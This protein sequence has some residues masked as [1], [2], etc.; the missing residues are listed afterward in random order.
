ML[1]LLDGSINESGA[2]RIAGN[3]V[4][5]A[6]ATSFRLS[7]TRGE[8]LVV[9]SIDVNVEKRT[10]IDRKHIPRQAAGSST[11]LYIPAVTS[12]KQKDTKATDT[13]DLEKALTELEQIV[14]RLEAGDLSLDESLK[15]FERGVQLTRQCQTALRTAEQKVDIL[16]RK[17]GT[18]ADAYGAELFDEP[19]LD[20]PDAD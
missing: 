15:Q 9:S 18:G 14:E 3:L 11:H 17:S 4:E 2:G 5:C 6:T 20:A 12:K 8:T 7:L 16:L 1:A 19:N 13:P 10:S